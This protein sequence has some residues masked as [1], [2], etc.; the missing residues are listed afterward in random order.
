MDQ[1]TLFPEQPP[2]PS[3]LSLSLSIDYGGQPVRMV[4]TPDRPE[5]VAADVCRAIGL[6][7]TG[8]AGRH[9]TK[10]RAGEN[11]INRI[12]TPGGPQQMATVTEPGLY[13][14]IFRSDK[15]EAERFQAWVFTDVLPSIRRHGCY[16]PPPPAAS[17][18]V[19]AGPLR[20]LCEAINPGT[21]LIPLAAVPSLPWLPRRPTVETVY[22][23]HRHGL[24]GIYLETA[25]VVGRLHTTE[26]AVLIFVTRTASPNPRPDSPVTLTLNL[27][28]GGGALLNAL[29]LPTSMSTSR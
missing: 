7:M 24:R 20:G 3:E 11:G 12:D 1:P 17:V 29:T 5:W 19:T 8:G 6:D 2:S 22:N 10:H 23:W 27:P 28:H 15:P 26:A 21:T 14:L 25:R 13:R 18:V 4:G 16:P 9:L